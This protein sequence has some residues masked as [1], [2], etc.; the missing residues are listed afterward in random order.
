MR[1]YRGLTSLGAT[2]LPQICIYNWRSSYFL[3]VPP[4]SLNLDIPG[5][6]GELILVVGPTAHIGQL[7]LVILVTGLLFL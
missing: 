6:F 7:H 2:D 1:L 5:G 3:A 4:P